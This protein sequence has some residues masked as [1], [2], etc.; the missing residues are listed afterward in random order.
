MSKTLVCEA[1]V[2]ENALYFLGIDRDNV[3]E[4]QV[5]DASPTKVR[6]ESLRQWAQSAACDAD[7]RRYFLLLNAAAA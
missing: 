6:L 1:T 7:R 4:Y 3:V 2:T 5:G